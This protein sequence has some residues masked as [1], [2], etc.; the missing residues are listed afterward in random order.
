MKEYKCKYCGKIFN[1]ANSIGGHTTYCR[2]NPNREKNCN[3]CSTSQKTY[4]LNITKSKLPI[5][6]YKCI[7]KKCG[8]EYVINKTEKEYN[9]GYYSKYCSTRCSH[10]R[11]HNKETKIKISN[12]VNNYNI[13]TNRLK[14]NTCKICGS[15][16]CTNEFCKK[17]QKYQHIKNLIKY[18]TFDEKCLGTLKVFEEY[19]RVKQLLYNDYIIH[20]LTTREIGKKY[21][22]KSFNNFVL[23]LDQLEIPRRTLKESNKLNYKKGLVKTPDS[24]TS[25]YKS[26][27]HI[28]WEGKSIFY[29]SS[30]ELN[31]AKILD[32]EH[33]S[34]D[35]ET[36]HIQY[37]DTQKNEI[38]TAIPD[39]YLVK[40]NMIVEIKSNYTLDYQNM[41]DKFRAYKDLGYN[42][43]CILEGKEEYIDLNKE[44]ETEHM[45]NTD[46]KEVRYYH[47]K[48]KCWVYNI[49]LSESKAILKDELN[50]YLE[51]GWQKGRKMF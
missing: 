26:G 23:I 10:S 51:K 33:I 39:F 20:E 18:F 27:T 19:D 46:T 45:Q 34:Y 14:K 47:M 41:R 25:K 13:K 9:K 42:Y 17:G 35:V 16:N 7:C 30:Y 50:I 3:S 32:E 15:I 38:R 2:E 37:Y 21:N 4:A 36:L 31:Y 12:S 11:I 6:E 40:D 49:E 29:R 24:S 5:Y 1:N 8:I 44:Y 48:D 28:T 22:Y 43:K